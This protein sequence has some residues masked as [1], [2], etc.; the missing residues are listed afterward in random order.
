MKLPYEIEIARPEVQA[1]YKAM[2][3][4]GQSERWAAMCALQQAP[5][6]HGTDRE[7][8]QGRNAGEFLNDMPKRQADFI[9]RE[10]KAAGIDISGK[11]YMSGI[12]D[13]RG[14]TDPEAWVS[15]RD[16]VVRVAKKRNLNMTGQ[17]NHKAEALPPPKSK[18]LNEKIV[19]RIQKQTGKSREQVI[20]DHG[21]HYK[22]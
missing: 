21:A 3:A 19:K 13:K 4:D 20:N 7:F 9:T 22:K 1:H 15:G 10:A 8:M 11:Y 2:I 16:D 18:P 12:A 5:G 14:W 17:V 6:C